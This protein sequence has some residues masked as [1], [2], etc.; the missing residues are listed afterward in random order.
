MSLV[1][2]LVIV[3]PDWNF[4]WLLTI[5]GLLCYLIACLLVSQIEME[6]VKETLQRFAVQS[7]ARRVTELDKLRFIQSILSAKLQ[8]RIT[9]Y[10]LIN[11]LTGL[12]SGFIFAYG[13]LFTDSFDSRSSILNIS[14]SLT[15]VS[16][17]SLTNVSE[18]LFRAV[19][20]VRNT[21]TDNLK[22]PSSMTPSEIPMDRLKSRAGVQVGAF[23]SRDQSSFPAAVFS[24]A[25]TQQSNNANQSY[26]D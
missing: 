23:S 11:L 8:K 4:R 19:D 9:V 1:L 12:S 26:F 20:S 17:V 13:V 21:S 25:Q 10:V 5:S 22:G 3:N 24:F 7:P 2:L 15:T 6:L 18:L 14:S 16:V